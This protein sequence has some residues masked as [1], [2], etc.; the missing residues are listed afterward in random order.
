MQD[1]NIPL[2]E[3]YEV[4]DRKEID[5]Q[6]KLIELEDIFDKEEVRQIET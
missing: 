5:E 3:R 2:R 4:M 6:F 1:K